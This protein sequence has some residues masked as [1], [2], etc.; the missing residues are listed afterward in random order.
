M[1]QISFFKKEAFS[2][3]GLLSLN[4]RKGRRALCAKRP[5]HLVL[6]SK[7]PILFQ[8]REWIINL[9]KKNA[10]VGGIKIY[11]LSIQKDHIHLSIRITS[12]DLY[13]GFIRAVTGLMARKLGKGLWKLPPFTRI[14]SWGRDFQ[15]V[16]GYIFKNEM[17]V[18]GLWAYQPRK[19]PALRYYSE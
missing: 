6:K 18:F 1:K 8:N 7:K 5:I 14:G 19:R 9:L 16:S 4:K 17:E 2:C 3:G 13:K 12:R 15:A 10:A 11:R